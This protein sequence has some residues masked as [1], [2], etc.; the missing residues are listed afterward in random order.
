LKHARY[1]PAFLNF[2]KINGYFLH[3]LKYMQNP[4]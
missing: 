2:S 1:Y 4:M 3:V